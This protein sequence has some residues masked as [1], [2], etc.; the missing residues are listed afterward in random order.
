MKV[1][2]LETGRSFVLDVTAELS[3]DLENFRLRECEHEHLEPR[4]VVVKGGSI[5]FRNQCLK[6]GRLIGTPIKKSL[7]SED[8]P[9]EDAKLREEYDASRKAEQ[10]DIIQRHV[11]K[12]REANSGYRDRYAK[13]L[14]SEKWQS[15]RARVL[16]RANHTCEGCLE[17]RATEVHHRT[18]AHVFD[19]LLYELVAL[20]DKCHRR[21]HRHEPITELEH[22]DL[23]CG[24]CQCGEWCDDESVSYCIK[25]DMTTGMALAPDGPCGPDANEIEPIA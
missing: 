5:Q 9:D 2:D 4:R 7:V 10:E 12:Q 1:M 17:E 21:S 23:P 6:C 18:Y 20:C 25:F 15:I 11:R 19:E 16:S 22:L 8:C 24:E 13:Y 3:R 14:K